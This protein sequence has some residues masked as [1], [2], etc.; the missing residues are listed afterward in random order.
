MEDWDQAVLSTPAVKQA[1]SLGAELRT[2]VSGD[3]RVGAG[4][5]PAAVSDR[6]LWSKQTQHRRSGGGRHLVCVSVSA[7]R[8]SDSHL[9]HLSAG[10]D[11]ITSKKRPISEANTVSICANKDHGGEKEQSWKRLR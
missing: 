4:K 9:L 1:P 7:Q 5:D 8:R 6:H 3:E 11:E 10:A 2:S